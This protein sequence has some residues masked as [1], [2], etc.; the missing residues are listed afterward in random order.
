MA[1]LVKARTGILV[2]AALWLHFGAMA[3]LFPIAGDDWR[4]L[5]EPLSPTTHDALLTLLVRLPLTHVVLTPLVAIALVVGTCRLALGRPV[6]AVRDAL[7]LAIASAAIWLS[8]ARTGVD[9]AHRASAVADL[10]GTCGAVWLVVALQRSAPRWF[11]LLALLAGLLVGATSREVGTVAAIG[12]TLYASRRRD[13]VTSAAA[14]GL[15]IG[16]VLVWTAPP[17]AR[18]DL[19]VERGATRYLHDVVFALR[20]PIVVACSVILAVLVQIARDL[21]PDLETTLA[22]SGR[23]LAFAIAVAAVVELSPRPDAI[24]M[25]PAGVA[26]AVAA[27]AVIVRLAA[28]RR[29]RQVAVAAVLLSHALIAWRSLHELA[30][31]HGD[32]KKRLAVVRD[33]RPGEIARV[34]PLRRFRATPYLLGEDLHESELRDRVATMMFGVRG[35]AIEP[36]EYGVEPVPAIELRADADGPGDAIAKLPTWFSADLG[37]A[38]DQLA[39]GFPTARAHGLRDVRL[40]ARGMQLP[41]RTGTPV[42]AAWLDGDRIE[43]LA[44]DAYDAVPATRYEFGGARLCVPGTPDEVWA[45]ALGVGTTERLARVDGEYVLPLVHGASFAIIACDSVRCALGRIVSFE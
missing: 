26:I 20:A 16:A 5:V 39:E 11:A 22:I 10:Y 44:I 13:A 3:W 42:L 17:A 19:L 43:R 27:T 36:L 9:L 7:P 28:D 24:S 35:I 31:A 18:L 1:V 8:S 30:I 6:D 33:T 21:R 37:T 45:I 34:P 38:R 41:A 29:V 23:S 2:L 40:V 12:A 32:A 15:V 14:I 25:F 4:V